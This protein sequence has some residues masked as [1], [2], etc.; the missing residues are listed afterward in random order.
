MAV[1]PELAPAAS[2]LGVGKSAAPLLKLAVSGTE[3]S[4]SALT[5]LARPNAAEAVRAASTNG[6]NRIRFKLFGTST[7]RT[8][9]QESQAL[10]QN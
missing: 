7:H 1:A 4:V 8:A 9:E 3:G 6:E 10:S 2:G 5:G